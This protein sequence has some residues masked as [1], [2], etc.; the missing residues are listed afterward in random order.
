MNIVV[1]LFAEF[2]ETAYKILTLLEK[3]DITFSVYSFADDDSMD[4][5]SHKTGHRI[6]R[7]PQVEVDGKLI[8][9]YYDIFEFLIN[10]KVINYK[11]EKCQ[12]M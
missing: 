6:R 12:T 4:S 9:S 10:K 1:Y 3:N 7:L 5:I 11:G 2:D 8:G